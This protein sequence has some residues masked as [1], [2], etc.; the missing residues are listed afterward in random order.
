MSNLR[1]DAF[2]SPFYHV[3][4]IVLLALGLV[5]LPVDFLF[6][7][8][9]DNTTTVK[10]LGGIILRVIL[11]VFAVI[12]IKKYGFERPFFT[13]NGVK[14]FIL[15]IPALIVAVNNFPF[16][17]VISGNA[18]FTASTGQTVLY[19][20]YCLSVGVFEELVYCGLVFPLVLYVFRHKKYSVVFATVI[21]SAIFGASHLLN[22]FGGASVGATIMQ[23]GYSFLIGAMCCI[24]K[25]VTRNL[26][27][28]IILHSIYDVGGL[29]FSAVGIAHGN[30]W[31][32]FT[33][34]ITAV[35]GVIVAI[36]MAIL[37]F[38]VDHDEVE[39][40]YFSE[41]EHK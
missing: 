25:C 6:G 16:S 33:V 21:S 8:F 36:Y 5:S 31:D 4:I 9:I 17:A 28:A 37:A 35:L 14:S 10:L 39:E 24:A 2:K 12:A 26:F 20:C 40:L 18:E 27:T 30:Q 3:A 34:I 32:T 11:A 13:N 29:L 1:K 22:I 41:I 23:V 19:I 7:L 38:K 15:I